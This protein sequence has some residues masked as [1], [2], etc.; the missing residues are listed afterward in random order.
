MQVKKNI[1]NIS[2]QEVFIKSHIFK[3]LAEICFLLVL[4]A[5]AI[6]I[7]TDSSIF[8]RFINAAPF[9]EHPSHNTVALDTGSSFINRD[10]VSSL[11][12]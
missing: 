5:G 7:W 1:Q 10:I 4:I 8:Y 3:V 11:A 6:A 9:M 12:L 2:V